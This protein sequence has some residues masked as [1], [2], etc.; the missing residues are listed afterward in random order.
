MAAPHS[1]SITAIRASADGALVATGGGKQAC[2]WAGPAPRW[3]VDADQYAVNAVLVHSSGA[4]VTTGEHGTVA[5]LDGATG[6]VRHTLELGKAGGALFELPDGRVVVGLDELDDLF[7]LDPITGKRRD[8]AATG[9]QNTPL[10]F[11]VAGGKLRSFGPSLGIAT[12]DLET[13]AFDGYVHGPDGEGQGFVG[14]DRALTKT[15]DGRAVLWRASDGAVIHELSGI[16][17]L[18]GAAA[19]PDGARLALRAQDGVHVVDAARGTVE[20]II[21]LGPWPRRAV[22]S[23]D[24]ARL[25]VVVDA[26]PNSTLTVVDASTGAPLDTWTGPQ[27]SAL[28][29][30]ARETLL[31]LS[32]GTLIRR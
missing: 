19:S 17:D 26:R 15:D 27:I 3:T 23:A 31:G 11:R 8:L 30:T 29:V 20:R 5:V 2:L 9:E 21:A 10:E 6:A 18:R 22:F 12:W 13:G 16:P 32:D 25:G 4:V 1:D 24:S 28:A 7:L 14:D